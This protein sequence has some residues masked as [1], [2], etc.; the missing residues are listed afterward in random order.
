MPD[1]H[2]DRLFGGDTGPGVRHTGVPSSVLRVPTASRG[3]ATSQ[4]C[5]MILPKGETHHDEEDPGPP[6]A[7]RP[8]P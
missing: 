4:R 8:R 7:A 3:K 1:A 6:A 2:P 5:P